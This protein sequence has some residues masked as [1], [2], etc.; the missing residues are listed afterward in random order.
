[1]KPQ[2]KT[3]LQKLALALVIKLL[4]LAALWWGFVRDQ[5][6]VVDGDAAAAQLLG[7]GNVKNPQG[8]IR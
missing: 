1:M 3:L 7:S 6:V 8:V 5:R 4:L 2:D